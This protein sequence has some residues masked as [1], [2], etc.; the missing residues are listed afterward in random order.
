LVLSNTV[1]ANLAWSALHDKVAELRRG[2]GLVNTPGNDVFESRDASGELGRFDAAVL[3][4]WPRLEH[5]KREV[6]EKVANDGGISRAF[7]GLEASMGAMVR[8]TQ[9]LLGH[10]ARGDAGAAATE[11]A[12]MDRSYGDVLKQIDTFSQTL[13]HVENT[14]GLA[15]LENTKSC[16]FWSTC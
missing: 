14:M 9:T 1:R 11:M 15:E 7:D 16:R 12:A 13:R 2:A 10:F 6:A 8:Q 3:A 5:L 4:F